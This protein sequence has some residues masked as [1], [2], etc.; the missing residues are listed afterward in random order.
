MNTVYI[1]NVYE[2][3]LPNTSST[4][5]FLPCSLQIIFFPPLMGAPHFSILVADAVCKF[6]DV[7]YGES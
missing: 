7:S 6:G 2:A 5:R 1:Y 4:L 3:Q